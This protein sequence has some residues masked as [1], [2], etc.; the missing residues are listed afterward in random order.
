LPIVV[1]LANV[2]A[3]PE[4]KGVLEEMLKKHLV[5]LIYVDELGADET[6]APFVYVIVGTDQ[7]LVNVELVTRGVADYD[8]S[9]AKSRQFD[10]EFAV[11]LDKAKKAKKGMW[12][13]AAVATGTKTTPAEV[14]PPAGATTTAKPPAPNPQPAAAEPAPEGGVVAE[15]NS[16]LHHLPT[17]A[18]AKRLSPRNILHYASPE[19]AERAG[20]IACARCQQK[21]ADEGPA[22]LAKPATCEAAK[23]GKLIGL[24]SDTKY[25]YSPV[26]PKL[27]NVRDSDMVGFSTLAEAK[28]SNREPDPYSLRLTPPPGA[29]AQPPGPGECIGRAPPFF[30]PC[31][32]APA[33][34][35]GLCLECQGRE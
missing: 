22:A 3:R 13:E 12:S 34:A 26:A 11:A 18:E 1:R 10:R 14:K 5:V 8:V 9:K 7:K 16:S 27:K 4:A 25:F 6:G 24:K 19:A 23:V 20:K 29:P 33:D 31:F 30:R 32:R 28:A 35:S 15:M 17:C 2:A 21:R